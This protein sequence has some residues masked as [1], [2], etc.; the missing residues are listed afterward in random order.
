MSG[1]A[2]GPGHFQDFAA[3]F[4]EI[5]CSESC[6]RPILNRWQLREVIVTSEGGPPVMLLTGEVLEDNA[7]W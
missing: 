2:V 7:L 1:I 5:G 6:K 4:S 3:W